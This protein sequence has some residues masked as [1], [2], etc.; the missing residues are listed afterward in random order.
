MKFA[1]LLGK[2]VVGLRGWKIGKVSGLDFD[3][4]SWKIISLEVRL[5]RHVAEEFRMKKVLVRARIEV[6]VSSIYAIGDHVVLSVTKPAL[7]RLVSGPP[8]SVRRAPSRPPL[9]EPSRT[10][11]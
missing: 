1:R 10:R 4:S 9:P 5:H 8:N 11:K 3:E 2:E 7:K 6:R